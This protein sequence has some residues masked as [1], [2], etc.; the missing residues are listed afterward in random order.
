MIAH[1][2]ATLIHAWAEGAT[3][4]ILSKVD[5]SWHAEE[6]PDW[7]ETYEYRVK[8]DGKH[9]QLKA[10]GSCDECGKLASDGWDLYCVECIDENK[11]NV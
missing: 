7:D 9:V 11:P 8:M 4:E 6:Y 10:R 5:G 2:H 3:V 1:K